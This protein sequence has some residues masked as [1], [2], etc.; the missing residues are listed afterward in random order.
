[1]KHPWVRMAAV[2]LHRLRVRRQDWRSATLWVL[3]LETGGLDPARHPILSVGMV[4][5]RDGAVGLGDAYYSLVR[6]DRPI[7]E[8]SLRI[9][10][11]LPGDLDEAPAAEQ[12]LADVRERI[13]D[14]ILVVHQ[15]SVDVPFLTHGFRAVGQDP[16]VFVVIDTVELL[17]RY[18]R[19]QGLVHMEQIR[20]STALTEAR[21]WFGLPRHR[22]HEALSDAV[23]TAELFLVLAHRLGARRLSTLL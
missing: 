13:G 9:H 15:W 23:A 16:P 22:S 18:A 3:D 1:M 14:G 10:H 6:S 2:L 11:I 21:E 12:V 19:R 17:L 8:E 7:G 4:P 5:V 20:F